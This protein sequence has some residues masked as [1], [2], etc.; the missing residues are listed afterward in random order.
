[1]NLLQTLLFIVF[2]L[3]VY[4]VYCGYSESF[5]TMGDYASFNDKSTEL[6][7]ADTYEPVENPS[8]SG[9]G[10]KETSSYVPFVPM[11][12]FTQ[13]SNNFKYWESPENGTCKFGEYCGN[14]YKPK[15]AVSKEVPAPNNYET[16]VNYF[17][18]SS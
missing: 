13:A 11:S 17:N 10:S 2:S 16:R 5:V 4:Y 7:L 9:H 18:A 1:M 8:F 3:G 6:L 15:T 14:V 12:S